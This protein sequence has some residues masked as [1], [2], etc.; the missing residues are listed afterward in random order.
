M[1]LEIQTLG[2][3]FI[4]V[5]L[6]FTYLNYKRKNYG[7]KSFISWLII[8]I[9]AGIVIIIPKTIYGFMEFLNIE[10]TQ[11]FFYVGAFIV[12]FVIVFNIYI[13]TKKTHNKIEKLVREQAIK[14]PYK[15]SSTKNKI[16][17]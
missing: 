2:L 13:T 4:A 8:W 14:N 9:I 7:S 11:D 10:R 5:M 16:K 6:Y 12:L 1:L 17:K 15:K 3:L